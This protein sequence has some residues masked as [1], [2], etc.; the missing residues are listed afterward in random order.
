MELRVIAGRLQSPDVDE[1]RASVLMLKERPASLEEKDEAI[2]LLLRAMQDP[3]WRVRKTAQEALIEGYAIEAYMERLIGLLYIEDN[4]GARNAAIELLAALGKKAAPYLMAAFKTPNAD[5]RKFIVDV[6]GQLK[7]RRALPLM[8]DALK[9]EDENVRAS[10]VEHLGSMAEP[11]VVDA[12][13]EILQSGDLWTA[14]PAAEALG[15]IGDK[16]ALPPL[17]ATLSSRPLREPA[18]RA[19]GKLGDGSSLAYIAPFIEDRSKAVQEETL[20]VMEALYHKGVGEDVITGRLRSVFGERIVHLLLENAW[21]GR[22]EVRASA[23][24]LLGL[25]RDERALEP[26][27]ELSQE[28]DFAEDVRRA[29]VFIGRERPEALLPLFG[30][31]NPYLR[32]FV[33]LAAAEVASGVY[34]EALSGLLG[35]ADGHVRAAAAMGLS[36][37]GDPGAAGPIRRLLLDDYADVQEAAIKA[38][39]GLR[40]G[41]DIASLIEDLGG[42]SA[43]LR[44]NTALLLGMLGDERAVSALGFALKDA[45]ISVRRAV[46]A[47]L[48]RIKTPDSVKHLM[49]ALT[50]E[51]TDVRAEAA[52]SLGLAKDKRALE[53]LCLLLADPEAMVEVAAARSLG[54]MGDRGASGHLIKAL[55]SANGFVVATAMDSLGKLGGPE[56]KKALVEMLSS[57]DTEIRRTAIRALSRF[58]DIEAVI[59]PF[60]RDGDWATRIAAVGVLGGHLNARIRE[61]LEKLLHEEEDA[62][63]RRAIEGYI[64]VR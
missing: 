25:L 8:L 27:L 39:A 45:D 57:A 21:S 23:I 33:C 32:R 5:V 43:L 20:R 51:D 30:K 64:N 22:P 38:L 46:V 2:G 54:T 26:L 41:L 14:Y 10:V 24:L 55:S 29:L 44:K 35:D 13:I 58:E 4:A 59:M 50:D 7:D 62:D 63:V 42:Q 3:S 31:E 49:L 34:Y 40:G 61:E 11:S 17:Y 15:R 60:V 19:I 6:L 36:K 1:R 18:I 53:P 12:L 48:C 56:A 47:A 28:A 52:L 37:I 9:D 16:R